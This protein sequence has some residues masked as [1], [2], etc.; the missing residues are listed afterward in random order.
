LDQGKAQVSRSSEE[1]KHRMAWR[2]GAAYPGLELGVLLVVDL[3]EAAGAM[4]LVPVRADLAVG[5]RFELDLVRPRKARALLA[6]RGKLAVDLLARD[7]AAL[8]RNQRIGAGGVKS[9]LFCASAQL[10]AIAI[11]PRA[12]GRKLLDL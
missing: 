1:V 7:L 5:P 12:F 8:D 3:A 11:I 9:R 4:G 6:D 2:E 10:N